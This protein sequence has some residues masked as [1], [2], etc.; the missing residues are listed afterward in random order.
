MATGTR[1]LPT[2]SPIPYFQPI[3]RGY[4]S[5]GS[6]EGVY[7]TPYI[8]P[9]EHTI[10]ISGTDY[11]SEITEM[12]RVSTFT[13]LDDYDT[14]FAARHGRGALDPV[15]KV[16]EQKST[17]TLGISPPMAGPELINPMERM[18]PIHGDAHPDQREQVKLQIAS[19]SSEI[20]GKGAAI[21]TDMTETIL[22]VLDKQVAMH[23]LAPN[24]IPRDYPLRMIKRKWS[25]VK[26][27][28]FLLKRKI[29]LT[30]SYP[31]WKIT[32]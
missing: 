10:N 1:S 8:E 26:K 21:F 25:K 19:P 3:E 27:Q 24:N 12:D 30:Y 14:L 11:H 7:A 31:L 13:G 18:M 15:P 29:I 5:E 22:D 4:M 9:S 32:G 20:I 6:Q 28:E 23:P 2:D 16:G 17:T